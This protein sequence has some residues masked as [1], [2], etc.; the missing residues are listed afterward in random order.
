VANVIASLNFAAQ[1]NKLATIE[2]RI[3]TMPTPPRRAAGSRQPTE[4]L[5]F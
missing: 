1:A 5:H 4:F 2:S 3:E